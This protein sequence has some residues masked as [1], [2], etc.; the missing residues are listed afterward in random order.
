MTRESGSQSARIF[1]ALP[2]RR[3]SRNRAGLYYFNARWYDAELGRFISEDPVKDGLNWYA[4]CSNNPLVFTDPTGLA[5]EW[6]EEQRKQQYYYGLL[7]WNDLPK[8][9]N[10][11]IRNIHDYIE[12]DP[13]GM[14]YTDK[15]GATIFNSFGKQVLGSTQWAIEPADV[16]HEENGNPVVKLTNRYGPEQVYDM[17]SGDLIENQEFGGTFNRAPPPY[18]GIN[19]IISGLPHLTD[20]INTWLK[21]GGGPDDLSTPEE[22]QI[23]LDEGAKNPYGSSYR[24]EKLELEE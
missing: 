12:L 8:N 5:D 23:R 7:T 24:N 4:Y 13:N 17:M 2:I 19:L 6:L 9:N 14:P 18:T 20:D 15:N 22:R 11:E 21:W 16:F 3:G 10:V 1:F